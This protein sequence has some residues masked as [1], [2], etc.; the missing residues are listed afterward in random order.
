M[1]D[2]PLTTLL[3]ASALVT[4]SFVLQ[5]NI[6]LD[7]A[8]EGFLWNGTLRIGQGKIPIR[9]YKSYDPGRFY[10]SFAWTKLFG[11]GILGIRGAAAV[12]TSPTAVRSGLERNSL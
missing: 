9:D 8:D 12:F 4:A 7:L 1:S 2:C 11:G 6:S 5:G 3:L 10:W